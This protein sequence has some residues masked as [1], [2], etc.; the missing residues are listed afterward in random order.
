[1]ALNVLLSGRQAAGLAEVFV[2]AERGRGDF[3]RQAGCGDAGAQERAA[4]QRRWDAASQAMRAIGAQL[5]CQPAQGA[6]EALE[7]WA[8]VMG[9]LDTPGTWE[10]FTC[11]ELEATA[12]LARAAGRGDV[13]GMMIHLH[14]LGD[15]DQEDQH[16][17]L[18][19]KHQQDEREWETRGRPAGA[20]AQ[21]RYGGRWQSWAV[22]VCRC[23]RRAVGVCLVAG[24][25]CVAKFV[26]GLARIL[27]V[28]CALSGCR[29][30]GGGEA[31]VQR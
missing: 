28:L 22:G 24:C 20:S 17:E 6:L 16:H 7:W 27:R 21:S 13:A 10:T 23:D 19:L 8:Q 26:G 15:Y 1:M 2:L 14:A 4:A 9:G 31:W 11:Q 3:L 29:V 30:L 5:A 25:W 18:Y 12:D